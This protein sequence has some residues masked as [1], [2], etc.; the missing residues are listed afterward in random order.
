MV[1]GLLVAMLDLIWPHRFSTVLEVDYDTPYDR[2]VLIVDSRQ[3]ARPQNTAS[4]PTRIL[5]YRLQ[6]NDMRYPIEV[7]VY[8]NISLLVIFKPFP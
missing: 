2:H 3:R 6:L 5:R 4:L 8:F 1:V 7:F